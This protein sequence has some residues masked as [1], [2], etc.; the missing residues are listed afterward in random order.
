MGC[1]IIQLCSERYAR[2]SL[3]EA[4]TRLSTRLDALKQQ[5]DALV[6]KRDEGVLREKDLALERADSR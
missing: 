5:R 3:D 6:R 1:M 2:L 4:S